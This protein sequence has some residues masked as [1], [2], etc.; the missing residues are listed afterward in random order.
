MCMLLFAPRDVCILLSSPRDVDI[1]LAGPR[2]M[3]ACCCL[4]QG[5]CVHSVVW[6]KG[7]VHAVWSKGHMYMLFN[8]GGGDEMY[9][10]GT[11]V[12]F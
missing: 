1:L 10:F 3:C 9:P 7:R 12:V 4:V 6:S 2:D 5:A 8:L 11:L